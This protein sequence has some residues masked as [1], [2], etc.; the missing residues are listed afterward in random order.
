MDIRGGLALVVLRR[1]ATII[2]ARIAAEVRAITRL[3][4]PSERGDDGPEPLDL[5]LGLVFRHFQH[6][7]TINIYKTM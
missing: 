3:A 7:I 4:T 6:E 5:L 1:V 2:D